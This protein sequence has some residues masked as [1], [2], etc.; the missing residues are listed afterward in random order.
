MFKKKFVSRISGNGDLRSNR[1][2]LLFDHIEDVFS[3][4]V[5]FESEVPLKYVDSAGQKDS[6]DQN[7]DGQE[8]NKA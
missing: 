4:S 5:N 1:I 6:F 3:L 7:G 8:G 2:D